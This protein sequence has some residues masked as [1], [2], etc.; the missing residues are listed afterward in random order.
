MYRA[1]LD[2][3]FVI[4]EAT[5]VNASDAIIIVPLY[6]NNNNILNFEDTPL[7]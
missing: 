3:Y 4:S 5:Y 2:V 6:I 7:V 1:K